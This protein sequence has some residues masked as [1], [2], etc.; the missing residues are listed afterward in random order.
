MANGLSEVV[1]EIL[2]R[3]AA[4]NTN[5]LDRIAS[6]LGKQFNV[7]ADEVALLG[8]TRDGRTL[9]FLLPLKLAE[10]GRIPLNSPA[11]LAARTARERRA[12]V[13]NDFHF[14]PHASVFE[15]VPVAEQTAEP[16]QKIMSAPARNGGELR[17]VVQ[18]SRK[19]KTPS[20]AGPDFSPQD[21]K[22]LG[23]A[24]DLLATCLH[25]F[26]LD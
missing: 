9:R 23:T 25:R 10:V 8:L 22:E 5:S 26:P 3:D 17:G 2:E 6:A 11:T 19:A 21:L 15:A 4:P 20:T 1:K 13:F 7:R 14:R 24:A 16:I 18:I 12:E